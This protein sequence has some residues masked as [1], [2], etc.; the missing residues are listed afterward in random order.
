MTKSVHTIHL[1]GR[2]PEIANNEHFKNWHKVNGSGLWHETHPDEAGNF[3]VIIQSKDDTSLI[4]FRLNRNTE[5]NNPASMEP[6]ILDVRE[7]DLIKG[8][9]HKFRNL[10]HFQDFGNRADILAIR[11]KID[12]DKAENSL[13]W[14]IDA[15]QDNKLKYFDVNPQFEVSLKRE[16]EL[17]ERDKLIP[18]EEFPSNDWLEENELHHVEKYRELAR[19][20]A[21]DAV[22]TYDKAYN[23]FLKT[24]QAMV[25]DANITHIE[26]FIW[27]DDLVINQLGYRGICDEWSVIQITLLRALGIPCCMKFI[28]FSFFGED[29]VHA[30]IEWSDDGVWRHMDALWNAFDKRHI[31]RQKGNTNVKVMNAS[32]P[33]DSRYNDKAW[34]VP[35]ITGDAK[36]YHYSDYLIEPYY[37][38]EARPGYSY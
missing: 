28:T 17:E 5:N 29:S 21:G 27:A 18:E 30:C 9:N 23:I 12:W 11:P 36:L 1:V 3:T 34:G 2:Y 14:E 20:W 10:E 32:L 31:Y 35:D 37:P 25:Y 24:K 8:R 19:E 6:E 15:R 13:S 4:G 33:R 38:G 22:T 26:H 16:K 7:F